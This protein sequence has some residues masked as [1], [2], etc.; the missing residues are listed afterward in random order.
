MTHPK[1]AWLDEAG[2]LYEAIRQGDRKV[3]T[4]TRLRA[5]ITQARTLGATWQEIGD[6][7]GTSR[8]YANKR[9]GP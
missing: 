6:A 5:A 2:D 1:T 3:E 7:M 4:E 8:Q 9:Y